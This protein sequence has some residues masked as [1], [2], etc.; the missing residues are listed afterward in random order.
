MCRYIFLFLFEFSNY[1]ISF[2]VWTIAVPFNHTGSK[3]SMI[4]T[5]HTTLIFVILF[6]VTYTKYL[7]FKNLLFRGDIGTNFDPFNRWKS[8]SF[9]HWNLNGLLPRNREKFDLVEAFVVS[10]NIDIFWISESFHLLIA[11]IID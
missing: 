2:V 10:N 4:F 9:Y 1:V 3:I 7:R 5:R 6:F 8:I 11:F